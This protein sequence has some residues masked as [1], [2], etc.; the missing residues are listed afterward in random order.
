VRGIDVDEA[1]SVGRTLQ[2]ALEVY[3]NAPQ[4]RFPDPPVGILREAAT[5]LV[6]A[7]RLPKRSD[8]MQVAEDVVTEEFLELLAAHHAMVAARL[9]YARKFFETL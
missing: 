3:A 7:A 6:N 4:N 5:R 2:R 1:K 9:N 8:D